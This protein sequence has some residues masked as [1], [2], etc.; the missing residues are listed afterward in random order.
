[1]QRLTRYLADLGADTVIAG[2]TE[3]PLVLGPEAS[4]L[5]MVSSTDALVGAALQALLEA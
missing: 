4:A 5:P 1:M 3:V 2:C